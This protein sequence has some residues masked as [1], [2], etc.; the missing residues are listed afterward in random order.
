MVDVYTTIGSG[1]DISYKINNV[2]D[3]EFTFGT[4][5]DG[6][7]LIIEGGALRELIGTGE[8]ALAELAQAEQEYLR[9]QA[10]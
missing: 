8:K 9:G 1:C 5:Q 3:V 2:D 7:T 10:S 6:S 4:S